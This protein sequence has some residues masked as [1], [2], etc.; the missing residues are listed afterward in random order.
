MIKVVTQLDS[1]RRRSF[2]L[3]SLKAGGDSSIWSSRSVAVCCCCCCCL[4]SV[5]NLPPDLCFL[6][7][8]VTICGGC[9][10]F[11]SV[12][13]ERFQATAAGV[14]R[15]FEQKKKNP[16]QSC[17]KSTAMFQ[18]DPDDSFKIDATLDLKSI[19]SPV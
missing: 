15:W 8:G 9:L 12:D 5:V 10:R 7:V 13:T 16:A 1:L 11:C 2:K 19:E 3:P 14:I 17:L 4:D 18:T 6:P